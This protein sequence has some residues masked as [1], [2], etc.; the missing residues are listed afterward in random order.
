VE[1]SEKR[2]RTVRVAVIIRLGEAQSEV[3]FGGVTAMAGYG[4]PFASRAS[5]LMPGHLVA[6][7][8]GPDASPVIIWRWYD[9]VVLEQSGDQVR[10]WEPSHGEV[11]ARARNE[12]HRYPPGTRAYTS[13]GLPG[14][15]W[16]VEGSVGPVEE[17]VVA[18]DQVSAFYTEHELWSSLT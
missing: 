11:L 6:V 15:D 1:S 14:A 9:A 2:S 7:S 10:L 18:I 16:W 17:A 8:S 12:Q 5:S 3:S 4:Q 13:A